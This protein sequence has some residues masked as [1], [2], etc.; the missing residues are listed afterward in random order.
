VSTDD[1]YTEFNVG[2]KVSFVTV[3]QS[4]RGS[5]SIKSREGIVVAIQGRVLAVKSKGR[6]YGVFHEDARK[7]GEKTTLTEAVE[8][9]CGKEVK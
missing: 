2:D 6:Q 4:A 1:N 5:I 3:T 8:H 7:A 9:L